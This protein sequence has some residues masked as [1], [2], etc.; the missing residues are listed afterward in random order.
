MKAAG[1]T[2][3]FAEIGYEADWYINDGAR[4]LDWTSVSYTQDII[5]QAS[6]E[7]GDDLLQDLMTKDTIRD[8]LSVFTTD[9]AQMHKRGLDYVLQVKKLTA[10]PIMY[11]S[12]GPVDVRK[13]AGA[14]LW[15]L[16]YTLRAAFEN[17]SRLFP[18]KAQDTNYNF[19][20][21][22]PLNS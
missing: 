11:V 19:V 5:I 3:D 20:P 18:R 15:T 21:I 22:T 1:V 14:A 12:K 10:L 17:I 9:I 2:L 6:R 4:P 16:D 8:N 13:A 7:G